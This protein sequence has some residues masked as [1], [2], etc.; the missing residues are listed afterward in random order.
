MSTKPIQYQGR[1]V[2][3]IVNNE[4][5]KRA[6]ASDNSVDLGSEKI[7]EIANADVVET[8]DNTPNVTINIDSNELGSLGMFKSIVSGTKIS[9]TP[10]DYDANGV[11]VGMYSGANLIQMKNPVYDFDNALLPEV[12]IKVSERS[13][14]TVNRT[15][16]IQGMFVS[17]IA[18]SY[19]VGGMAKQTITF[20]SDNKK[21]YLGDY[22]NVFTMVLTPNAGTKTATSPATKGVDETIIRCFSNRS[23][24]AATWVGTTVTFT[25]DENFDGTE[26]VIGVYAKGDK[27][28]VGDFPALTPANTGSKGGFRRGA[29]VIYAHKS[30]DSETRLLRCQSASYNL[31]F[32][33]QAKNE[34]GTQK[35]IDRAISY[36]LTVTTDL[37]FDASDLEAFAIMQGKKADYDAG[38]LTE[39]DVKDF[40]ND[41]TIK[42]KIYS[43]EYD[44]SSGK[45]I[46]TITLEGQKVKNESDSVQAGSTSTSWKVSL[47]GSSIVWETSGNAI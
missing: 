1:A 12:L 39:M 26:R 47:E 22:K 44:H 35:D 18:G 28:A 45:L 21:W 25:M 31:S 2:A 13:N 15:A 14:T 34:L 46:E 38:T 36:P 9:A 5:W 40:I 4:V 7:F 17:S 30:T 16:H 32:N 41:V 6:Q 3:V 43:D 19:D 33:R 42:V 37:T 27:T 24:F 11:F 8:K 10:G 23:E 29:I 20:E